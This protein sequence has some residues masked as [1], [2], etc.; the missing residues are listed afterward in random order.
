M[1]QPPSNS[2]TSAPPAPRDCAR[3]ETRQPVP[4]GR[5]STR[6]GFWP[7]LQS[8]TNLAVVAGIAVLIYELKLTRELASVQTV[9][10][11]YTLAIER[12]LALLGNAPEE[13][14]ARSIFAPERLTPSD[15]IVLNQYF[16]SVVTNWVR[17]KD[18]RAV[19]YFGR[20]WKSVVQLEAPTLNTPIGRRWWAGYRRYPDAELVQLVDAALSE[21]SVEESR[22]YFE[23]LLP[24]PLEAESSVSAQA[25]GPD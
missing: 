14:L 13:V 10:Q 4:A 17:I 24:N 23:R 20:G 22:A 25:L 12:N 8:L 21:I 2:S 6:A 18:E 16:L 9:D 5:D 3:D 19:G 15:V 1:P 11:A 7:S